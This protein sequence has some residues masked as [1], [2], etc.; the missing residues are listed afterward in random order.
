MHCPDRS[1]VKPRVGPETSMLLCIQQQTNSHP[2]ADADPNTNHLS[3]FHNGILS[4][5]YN[6][7]KN[8]RFYPGKIRGKIGNDAM[9]L[10][11]LNQY[12]VGM[13]MRSTLWQNRIFCLSTQLKNLR[14]KNQL[15]VY[16]LVCLLFTL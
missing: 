10:L 16:I 6:T 14:C 13:M 15:F 9:H 3:D 5:Q 8:S 1:F 2:K 12:F 7:P 11:L 4:A